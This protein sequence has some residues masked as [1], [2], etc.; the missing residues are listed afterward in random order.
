MMLVLTHDLAVGSFGPDAE[1]KL[2]LS[3]YGNGAALRL[4]VGP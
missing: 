3:D 1:G 2:C 4:C